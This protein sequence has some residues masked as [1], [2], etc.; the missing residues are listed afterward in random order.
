MIPDHHLHS[1]GQMP[2]CHVLHPMTVQKVLD[3]G[4]KHIDEPVDAIEGLS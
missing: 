4:L 2:P 1:E 3:T